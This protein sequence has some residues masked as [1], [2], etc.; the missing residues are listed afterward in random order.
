MHAIVMCQRFKMDDIV[1]DIF[2]LSKNEFA[3]P[4]VKKN[5]NKRSECILK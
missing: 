3:P 1:M 2:V 5:K 4:P